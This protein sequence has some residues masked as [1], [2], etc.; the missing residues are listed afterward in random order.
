[1]FVFLVVFKK[2]IEYLHNVFLN[3]Y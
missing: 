3:D 2:K 1:M